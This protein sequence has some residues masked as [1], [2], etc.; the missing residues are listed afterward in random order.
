MTATKPAKA[1]TA[2]A[3]APKPTSKPTIIVGTMRDGELLARAQTKERAELLRSVK[4]RTASQDAELKS[5]DARSNV[6]GPIDPLFVKIK[7]LDQA[8][9]NLPTVGGDFAK[10]LQPAEKAS[11]A[12]YGIMAHENLRDP[13]I[14]QRFRDGLAIARQRY[15]DNQALFDKVIDIVV[16]ETDIVGTTAEIDA[17]SIAAVVEQHIDDGID[18]NNPQLRLRTVFTLTR[19]NGTGEGVPARNIEINL[20]D[21]ESDVDAE[22]VEANLDAMQA[23]Y[24]AATLEEV[25]LFQVADKLVE[26]FNQGMLPL[27]R[28]RGGDLLFRY[29]KRSADRFTEVERRNLYARL[30]GL[31]GGEAV[32]AA[33]N[34]EYSDLWLRFV[35]AVSSYK[36]QLNLDDL[37]RARTPGGVSQEQVRKAGRD[38]AANLS[39]YGYGMAYFAATELQNQVREIIEILSDEEVR[40]S[41]GARDLW[42]VVDQVAALELGGARNAVRYRTMAQSGAVIIRWLARNAKR[43]SAVGGLKL[44]DEDTLRQDI[45]NSPRPMQAPTDVD[46]VDACEQWLAVTGTPDQRVEEFAQP[47]DSPNTTSRPVNIPGFARDILDSSPLDGVGLAVN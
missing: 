29:W 34:R 13:A 14:G 7:Q 39:L 37:L 3:A 33:P 32:Q 20:P 25:K 42:Q 17:E 22:I 46:L 36:R 30:F 31:P 38:L 47:S 24:F 19:A 9:G 45:A 10:A 18:A 27:G 6:K 8:I 15:Y 12:I 40:A 26:L 23:I 21:L 1:R 11:I 2:A 43:L 41:Y 4:G 35:S 16:D 44:L 5:L 28:G